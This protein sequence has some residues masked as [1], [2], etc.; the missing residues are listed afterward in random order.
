M[1]GRYNEAIYTLEKLI[2]EF[3]DYPDALLFISESYHKLGR[4]GE[5]SYY[6]GLH[7]KNKG[8]LKNAHFHL[9]MALKKLDDQGKKDK[10]KRLLKS[11][12]KQIA[13]GHKPADR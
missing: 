12:D 10:I 2:K 8:E 5:S 7:Y 1:L 6:L 3:P 13:H 4:H 9:K 11:I